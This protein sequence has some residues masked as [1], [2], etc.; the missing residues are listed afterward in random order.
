ML[1][2]PAFGFDGFAVHGAADGVV[3]ADHKRKIRRG[4]HGLRNGDIAAG[5]DNQVG[6]GWTEQSLV[7]V[8]AH[9]SEEQGGGEIWVVEVIVK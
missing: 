2:V 3:H 4:A 9:E 6:G 5:R 8:V 1:L 7:F